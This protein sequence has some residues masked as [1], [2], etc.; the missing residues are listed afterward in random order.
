M[1]TKEMLKTFSPIILFSIV[2][3]FIDIVTD[4]RLI[5]RLFSGVTSCVPLMDKDIDKSNITDS[6]ISLCSSSEDLSKFGQLPPYVCK[7]EKLHKF[8][9]SLLGKFTS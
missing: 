9:I 5:I 8:A 2:L 7:H 4:L 3:P 1:N 6:D